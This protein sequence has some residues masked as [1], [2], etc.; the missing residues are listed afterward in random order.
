MTELP[1]CVISSSGNQLK[2]IALLFLD[3]RFCFV[4][5]ASQKIWNDGTWETQWLTSGRRRREFFR[6]FGRYLWGARGLP[7]VGQRP[8]CE[9]SAEQWKGGLWFASLL[10]NWK[11]QWWRGT[12]RV[13]EKII[14]VVLF[15]VVQLI[16][17]HKQLRRRPVC[18]LIPQACS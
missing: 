4:N 15:L 12:V 1:M 16:N 18:L 5:M 6:W 7:L 9:I 3:R 10:G 17:N 14:S 8:C 2:N 13:R 11:E